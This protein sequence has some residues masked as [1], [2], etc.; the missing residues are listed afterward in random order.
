MEKYKIEKN[1]VQETLII[2]LYGRRLCSQR[3]P[4]LYQ[5]TTA[6]L[7]I[8]T[9]EYYFTRLERYPNS[10]M[11]AFGALGADNR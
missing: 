4:E 5:G 9:L 8:E 10:R 2:P 1:S 3:F 7:L 11:H 6:A